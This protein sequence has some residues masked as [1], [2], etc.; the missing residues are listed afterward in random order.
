VLVFFKSNQFAMKKK[1]NGKLILDDELNEKQYRM[2]AKV[3][4]GRWWAIAPSMEDS[5]RKAGAVVLRSNE[6]PY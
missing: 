5:F 3:G 4:D 1:P 6:L 2:F